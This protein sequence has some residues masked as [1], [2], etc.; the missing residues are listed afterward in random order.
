MWQKC[1][2]GGWGWVGHKCLRWG[3]GVVG[4][5]R[6]RTHADA[7]TH[8][9]SCTHTHTHT[10]TH[11]HTHRCP[12]N[13]PVARGHNAFCHTHV[14]AHAHV[15]GHAHAHEHMRVRCAALRNAIPFLGC[16]R[17][18]KRPM[19]CHAHGQAHVHAHPFGSSIEIMVRCAWG[20]T[21]LPC[22]AG[23]ILRVHLKVKIAPFVPESNSA[24]N[25]AIFSLLFAVSELPGRPK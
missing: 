8:A 20:R 17:M 13:G 7:R 10:N 15:H 1:P 19:K 25:D 24:W 14:H 18:A 22:G 2:R 23:L 4:Q 6:P 12:S 21:F 11:T 5:M 16:G 3:G 9:S